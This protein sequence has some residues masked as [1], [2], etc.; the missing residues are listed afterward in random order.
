LT[1]GSKRKRKKERERER[2]RKDE[3]ERK[4]NCS[5]HN[6]THMDMRHSSSPRDASARRDIHR[7]D[8]QTDRQKYR[9]R[10]IGWIRR[11]DKITTHPTYY[12][13]PAHIR[14]V[15]STW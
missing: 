3:E 6:V 14:Q 9:E 1:I 15:S 7:T 11:K 10:G 4:C 2:E 12:T 13:A 5:L 8:R